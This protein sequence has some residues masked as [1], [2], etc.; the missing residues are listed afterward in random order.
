ML[1][2]N[3]FKTVNKFLSHTFSHKIYFEYAVYSKKFSLFIY[4]CRRAS[5]L[6]RIQV[7]AGLGEKRLSYSDLGLG[8]SHRVWISCS[9]SILSLFV[10][11][12]ATEA[13][14]GDSL[15][16]NR[17]YTGIFDIPRS[18]KLWHFSLILD[19]S[20]CAPLIIFYVIDTI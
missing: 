8:L 3:D 18:S 12:L 11:A 7:L 15:R 17:F 9:L 5:L 16:L 10:P 20:E 4:C 2:K 13:C 1:L 19:I 6:K 14:R